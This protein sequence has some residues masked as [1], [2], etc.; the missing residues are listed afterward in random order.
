[1]VISE[2]EKIIEP[3]KN[4]KILNGVK[5]N[6]VPGEEIYIQINNYSNDHVLVATSKGLYIF[7]AGFMGG[8][9]F[10]SKVTQFPYGKITGVE[11]KFNL[12]SGSFEVYSGSTQKIVG[13]GLNNVVNASNSIVIDKNDRGKFERAVITIRALMDFHSNNQQMAINAP[14]ILDQI[15]RLSDLLKDGIIT[16][17]EFEQKK[18]ILLS[19]I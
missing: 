10:G 12:L 8:A 6:I 13:I 15:R 3:I 2:S 19:K 18:A 1:M 16:N 11:I 17:G 14:D 5:Q 4:K 7:K 9:T